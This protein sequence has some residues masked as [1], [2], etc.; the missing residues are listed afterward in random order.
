MGQ[1]VK[2]GRA[3]PVHRLRPN[4]TVWTPPSVIF[5]DTETRWNLEGTSEVH[6]MRLWVACH[7]D[8]RQVRK[9]AGPTTWG[10]GRDPASLAEWVD[11]RTRGRDCVWLYAHNLNFDLVVS[12][13]P[14]QMAAHGWT[15][16]DFSVSQGAPWIRFGKKDRTL[17]VV[18][19]WAWLP[20]SL[21]SLSTLMGDAKL[22]L[23]AN[24][25]GEYE[26]MGR[27]AKDVDL[28]ARS[29]LALMDWWDARRLGRWSISGAGS[30]WNAMRHVGSDI[31]HVIDPDPDLIAQDRD[32]IR[33]GRK[34]AARVGSVDGGPWVEL[35]LV[36]AYPTVARELPLPVKRAWT[37]DSLPLDSK[38]V[39]SRFYSPSAR[40]LVDCDVPRYPLRHGGV[41]WYPVGRFW[42]TLAGPELELA[43]DAG[44]LQAIGAGQ[45]HRLG[46]A[47]RPWATWV[48]DPSEGG[49]V[50]VPAVAR[51]ATKVWGR[52]V[53]GKFAARSHTSEAW[54]GVAP[55]GWEVTD[56]WDRRVG[57]RAAEVAMAGQKWYVTYDGD[58]ENCYPAVL[59]WV[60]SHVRRRLG[61]VLETLDGAWWTCDTDGLL[62]DLQGP[63]QWARWGML[64]LGDYA[65]D[66]MGLAQA[67]CDQL[68]PIVAPL[69][70]RPKRVF[71]SLAVLGPQ[72]L[73]VDGRRRM[74][75]VSSRAVETAPNS[76]TARDWPKLKWQMRNSRPG[77]Y[78]R[79]ERV[80]TFTGPTVHR[81]VCDDGT[82]RPVEFRIGAD[83]SN[84]MV[85]WSESRWLDGHTHLAGSQYRLLQRLA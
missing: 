22:P 37:F 78:T 50:D 28:L 77:A 60:E 73:T 7:V 83:G 17:T 38:W 3:V 40:V 47:L 10:W 30:G 68:A 48:L 76:F 19:S 41:T 72:H 2:N 16:G 59:A 67:L 80:A 21:E 14:A 52:S 58:T 39:H 71:T 32:A 65:R 62:V 4:E 56:S 13:L 51:V 36:G 1:M 5:L 54:E 46:L 33:G 26:W 6:T 82:T 61:A 44:D 55:P 27:C 34:D 20:Q 25:G 63:I 49:T 42:T 29:V 18:D 15:V 43:H 84:Q 79:P 66:P 45:M 57:R 9:T 53:L 8:R 85:P 74:A 64:R 69:T 11:G 35:D 75:G 70:L 23:P 12:D 81:W 31:R 24:D